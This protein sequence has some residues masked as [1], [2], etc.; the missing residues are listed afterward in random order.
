MTSKRKLTRGE[1]WSGG[2]R[3][4][5]HKAWMS[6][7]PVIPHQKLRSVSRSSISLDRGNWK[8]IRSDSL[9]GEMFFFIF[10]FSSKFFYGFLLILMVFILDEGGKIFPQRNAAFYPVFGKEL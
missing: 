10:Y 2:S 3:S 6:S 9:D 8:L 7:A 4:S 1:T 5:R